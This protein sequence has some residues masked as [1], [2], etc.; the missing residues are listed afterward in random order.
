MTKVE[1]SPYIETALNYSS[2]TSEDFLKF[3]KSKG[4]KYN[5]MDDLSEERFDKLLSEYNQTH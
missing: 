1:F 2:V 3:L 5:D 4:I